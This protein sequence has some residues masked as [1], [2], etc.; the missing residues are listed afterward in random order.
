MIHCLGLT[1]TSDKLDGLVLK[2]PEVDAVEDVVNTNLDERSDSEW[3]IEQQLI[4]EAMQ[5]LSKGPVH[6][7]C[8]IDLS[9]LL[10]EDPPSR[11]P[12]AAPELRN[13]RARL[14]AL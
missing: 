3:S 10:D 11:E 13:L 4:D 5:A 8:E 1:S 14:I 2:G 6:T 9:S 7:E 12:E